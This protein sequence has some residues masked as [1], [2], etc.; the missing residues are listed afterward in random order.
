[1]HPRHVAERIFAQI[2]LP[3]VKTRPGD[4]V[5]S[6]PSVDRAQIEPAI[7]IDAEFLVEE[8]HDAFADALPI[9]G[10]VAHKHLVDRNTRCLD[11]RHRAHV[12]SPEQGA[13]QIE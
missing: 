1:M 4:P 9:A 6:A 12:A 5:S 8:V 2:K 7:A 11:P 13:A 10:K 3:S